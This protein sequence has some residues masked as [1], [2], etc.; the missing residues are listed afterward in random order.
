VTIRGGIVKVNNGTASFKL[1]CPANSPGN[2][3]GSLAVRTAQRVK[4]AGLR[5]TLQLG[6]ARY[7]IAPGRSRTLKV[8]LANGSQ[9]LSG[10]NRKLRVLAIASTGPQGKV[11][12]SS[13]R[14]TLAFG[15]A[16]KRK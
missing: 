6:S 7:T 15:R 5:V 1:S 3:T 10:G 4:L 12:Q 14:L 2:C 11:A 16:T 8:K 13:R 9:R